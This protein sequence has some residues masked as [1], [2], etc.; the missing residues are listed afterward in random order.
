MRII[1]G[2][3][4]FTGL[5]WKASGK[6]V[7][8]LI[9]GMAVLEL[10][11]I[12]YYINGGYQYLFFRE[13]NDK[14]WPA[15]YRGAL[16]SIRLDYILPVFAV[17]LIILLVLTFNSLI[18]HNSVR[19]ALRMPVSIAVYRFYQVFHSFFVI[20]LVWLAQY[21]ILVG[22]FLL[23]RT[24]APAGLNI[25]PQLQKIFSPPGMISAFYPLENPG[26]LTFFILG[27]I[28]ACL[29]PSFLCQLNQFGYVSGGINLVLFL[30]IWLISILFRKAPLHIRTPLFLSLLGIAIL[31]MFWSLFIGNP[32]RSKS[33]APEI[34]RLNTQNERGGKDL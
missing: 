27:F 19:L 14:V 29:L 10:G 28:M 8:G 34:L 20:L 13:G 3:W 12:L 5:Y 2:F 11:F 26:F 16:Q 17:I 15:E 22:G 4:A 23:Y 7:L 6:W 1:K 24:G 31:F 33:N 21:V 30:V 9:A 18:K 32:F 25:D